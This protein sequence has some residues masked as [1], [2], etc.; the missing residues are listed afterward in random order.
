MSTHRTFKYSREIYG[1]SP[2]ACCSRSLHLLLRYAC[3]EGGVVLYA[4]RTSVGRGP[5][6]GKC[7]CYVRLLFEGIHSLTIFLRLSQD[8]SRFWL[9]VTTTE[10][11]FIQ[12]FGWGGPIVGSWPRV[13][14]MAWRLPARPQSPHVWCYFINVC[15]ASVLLSTAAVFRERLNSFATSQL[16]SRIFSW[17]SVICCTAFEWFD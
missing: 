5:G 15:S 9:G 10:P 4:V 1:S 17:R 14:S 6:E 16:W 3:N 12:G 13:W 11:G 7:N 2:E 8:T